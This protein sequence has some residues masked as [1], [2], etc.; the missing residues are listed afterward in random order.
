MVTANPKDKKYVI[1]FWV[2]YVLAFL[3]VILIFVLISLGRLGPMPTFEQLENPRRNLAS[4][5]YSED[6]KLLGKFYVQN[7]VWTNYE[8]ISPYVTDALVAT[9]DVR[10]F[11]HSGI[12]VR[13]L[14]RV[15][16]KTFLLRQHTAGGG[17]T[18][19]Q[20]LAKNLFPRDTGYV[21]FA[22]ARMVKLALTKFKEWVTAVKLERSYTK[23]EIIDM[24]L[25]VFDF[26]Y[27]AVG[28]HSAADIYF[29]TT[30]DSLTLEQ[31]AMLVGM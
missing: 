12:D 8:D 3:S 14:G 29:Q 5:V 27:Q 23:E 1:W 6:G 26:L 19:S 16:V 4:E 10:F 31:A 2:L 7:R 9:E 20:Q 17:S 15:F 30:P 21:H 22:P 24:Y 18:I 25:N 28:I 11:R 13:G